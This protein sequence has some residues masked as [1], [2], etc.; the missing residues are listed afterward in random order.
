MVDVV[1]DYD[2][3]E[4]LAEN[5]IAW[6]RY[7]VALE[8]F[9]TISGE[10]SWDDPVT[11]SHIRIWLEDDSPEAPTQRVFVIAGFKFVDYE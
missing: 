7:R 3:V 9:M 5:R 11:F 1:Y 8:D 6:R 10:R 2:D 4:N